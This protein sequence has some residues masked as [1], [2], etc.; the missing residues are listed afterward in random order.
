MTPELATLL[1]SLNPGPKIL[2]YKLDLEPIGVD[3]Q[4]YFTPSNDDG[5]LI[6]VGGQAYTWA[7]VLVQGIED[8]A[9]GS[10]P[11][12]RLFLPNGTKFTTALVVTHADLVGAVVTRIVTFKDFLDGQPLEN[13]DAYLRKHVLRV[14]QK[15]HLGRTHGEF[16]LRPLYS[17]GNRKIPA[18]VCLKE[19]C[20][21]RYRDGSSGTFDY[22]KATCPYVGSNKFKLDGTA[23]S[24][25]DEDE[26]ARHLAACILRHPDPTPLPTRAFPGMSRVRI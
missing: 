25:V 11:E 1:Q 3:E 22:S 4:Y 15:L 7:N 6:E 8:S 20:T 24:N 2:L 9:D 26:C 18:R 16:A 21:H 19:I 17:V 10:T 12:P 14:E 23:T 5:A 13:P